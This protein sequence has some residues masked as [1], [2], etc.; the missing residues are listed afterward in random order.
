[1]IRRRPVANQWR[2]WT[3]FGHSSSK[4]APLVAPASWT[5]ERPAGELADDKMGLAHSWPDKRAPQRE[6]GR[7]AWRPDSIGHNGRDVIGFSYHRLELMPT[8]AA[9]TGNP[10]GAESGRGAA[11]RR[12]ESGKRR[13]ASGE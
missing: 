3:S 9:R 8:F 1:M 4:R 5:N 10:K 13:L 6:A 7:G 12:T 2:W 11:G